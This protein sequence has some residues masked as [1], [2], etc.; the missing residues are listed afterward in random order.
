MKDT[1]GEVFELQASLG[2]DTNVI[3]ERDHR[4]VHLDGVVT[5]EVFDHRAK[6]ISKLGRIALPS[7]VVLVDYLRGFN[8]P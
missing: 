4:A 7:D 6:R 3:E 2:V 8:G 5:N 1:T